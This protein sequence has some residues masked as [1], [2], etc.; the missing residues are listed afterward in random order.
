MMHNHLKLE[1]L[2]EIKVSLCLVLVLVNS[3]SLKLG[4]HAHLVFR[5]Y[6]LVNQSFL[7]SGREGLPGKTSSPWLTL[8]VSRVDSAGYQSRL[9]WPADLGI[10]TSP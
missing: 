8:L 10:N 3:L 6:T 7:Q 2:N 4:C 5:L 1:F 9:C